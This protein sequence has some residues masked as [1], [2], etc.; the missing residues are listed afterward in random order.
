MITGTGLVS[1]GQS[2]GQAQRSIAYGSTYIV[3]I[4]DD[5]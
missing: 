3:Y 1:L 2:L 4:F 5:W